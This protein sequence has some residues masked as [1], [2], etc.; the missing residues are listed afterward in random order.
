MGHLQERIHNFVE[1]HIIADDP[2][3]ERSWLDNLA[4]ELEPPAEDHRRTV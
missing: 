3:P 4:G 1:K 2:C